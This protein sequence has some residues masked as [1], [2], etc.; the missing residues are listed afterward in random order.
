[1]VTKSYSLFHK[2]VYG[3]MVL[4]MVISA[5]GA[6]NITP[7]RAQEAG[8]ETPTETVTPPEPTGTSAPVSTPTI[9]PTETATPPEATVTPVPTTAPTEAPTEMPAQPEAAATQ[10][11]IPDFGRSGPGGA[12]QGPNGLWYMPE[13]AQEN[14]PLEAQAMMALSSSSPD[15]FGYTWDDSEAF[16]WI[17]TTGGTDTGLTG[18]G[19][20]N[21]TDLIALPFAF[22][23]YENTYS[24]VNIAAPGTLAFTQP[25]YWPSQGTIP[26]P[27]SPN[28]VIAPYWTPTYIGSGGWVHYTSGGSAPNRFFVVEWHDLTG[29]APGD[30][31][32]EDEL[33]RFEVILHENGDIVFQY[34]TMTSTGG[35]WCGTSGIEDSIGLDGLTYKNSCGGT[36][37]PSSATAVR[38]TRPAASA[39]VGLPAAN[40]GRF[41]TAGALASFQVAIRNIGELGTDTYDLTISSPWAAALYAANGTTLLT[42]TDA[43][44]TVDTGSVPQGNSATVIV[45]LQTPPGA[46]LGDAN[47][48]VLTARS[49]VNTGKSKT[50]TLKTAV[51]APFVQVYSDNADGAMSMDLVQPHAQS[52]QPAT[53]PN[54]WGY[55][56]AIARASGETYVYAWSKYGYND[57][58]SYYDLEFTLLDNTGNP[59][60]SV[61]KLTDNS[62]ETTEVADYY[63]AVAVAPDGHIG[64][65]WTHT[66]YTS[67]FSQSL[68]NVFFAILDSAGNMVMGPTNV[69]NNSAWG[70]YGD[71]NFSSYDHNQVSASGD[72]H[73]TLA[74]EEDYLGSSGWVYQIDYAVRDSA[75][76]SIKTVTQ[77]PVSGLYEFHSA[78]A[79]GGNRT[80]L[81][82][83]Y[84]YDTYYAVLDSAGSVVKGET[85]L[86]NNGQAR[87]SSDAVL[88]SNGRT[89]VAWTNYDGSY[90]G[91]DQLAFAIL[92]TSFNLY[93]GPTVLNNPAA[94]TGNNYISITSDANGH[95]ILTWMDNNSSN[96]YYALVNKSGSVNTQP[97]I[98]LTSQ[99]MGGNIITSYFGFGNASYDTATPPTVASITRADASPTSAASVRFNVTFSEPVTGVDTSDF[100]L[101]ASGITGPAV[102]GISGSLGS[103]LVTVNT[104]SG[105]GTLRLNVNDNDSIIDSSG[106][107]LG[108]TGIGNGNFTSGETYSVDKGSSTPP[109][110]P[111]LVSPADGSLS[112]DF[113]PLLDWSNSTISAG[114]IFGHYQVQVATDAAFSAIVRDSNITGISNSSY[115][116]PS[117][118]VGSTIY[119]WRVRAFNA[120][121]NSSAW[122]LVRT[123]HTDAA[124][125]RHGGWLDEIDFSVVSPGSAMAQLQAGAI[126]TYADPL[127]LTQKASIDAAGLNS[128]PVPGVYYDIMYNGATCTDSNT[129]NPFADRKIREATNRLYDR[130]YLN[131]AI[132][133]GTGVPKF[134]VIQ[135]NSSDYADLADIASGLEAKYAFN[136]SQAIADIATEMTNLGATLV[137]GKWRFHGSPVTLHFLVRSD[138]DGTRLPMGDYVTTQLVKAGFTV[139]EQ[140][141]KSSEA[142]PIWQGTSVECLWNAYTAGWMY[143]GIERD[144]KGDFQQMYLPDSIQGSQPFLSNNPDPVFQQVGDDLAN[145][146]F[147]TLLQRHDLMAQAMSLS[148]QDSLQVFIINS[149]SFAPYKTN[150][151]MSTNLASGIETA[152]IVFY[153]AHI[154]GLEGGTLKWGE[155]DLFTEP[156]NPIA[157]SNW[158][159]DQGAQAATSGGAFMS[160]PYTGLQWPLRAESAELTVQTGLPIFKSLDWITLSSAATINVPADAWVDWNATTQTFVTAGS[161]ITAKT[162]STITYPANMFD[163][164]TW[165]DG[166]KLSVADFVM[167]M[168]M[169]FDRAKPASAIYDDQAVPIFDSFMSSFKGVKIVSTSPLVIETYSDSF[170]ADAE[171]DIT[172]WWPNYGYGEASWD[173]IAVANLAEADGVSAYSYDKASAGAIDQTNFVGG[174]TLA[175]LNGYLN[176]AIAANTIP[177]APTMGTYLT[178][179]EATARYAAL[180]AFYTAHGHFW[181]GTGPYYLDTLNLVE[182][183]LALRNFEQYPDL[184]NR[185]SSFTEPRI[186]A[187][188]VT[189]P[190]R[191]AVGATPTF[192]IAVSF[193]GT[194]YP[195]TDIRSVKYLLFD[196][197]GTLVNSGTAVAVGEG[198]F[199]V[200]L[201]HATVGL[202]QKGVNRI[203]AVVV[204]NP[205]VIP[206]FSSL[207]FQVVLGVRDDYDGDGKTD[208]A[209]FYPATG[210][211]WWVKSSTGLWDGKWLGS[212]TFTYVGASDFDGDGKTDP[213]KF[214]PATGTVWWVKSS[215]G[216]LDGQWLGPD[217]FTFITGS[218]FDGDGKA[219]PAKFYPATGTVWW[220]KSTTG[221]LD[222]QWLGG[223]SFQYV[224]GSDFDGDGK[225][226]PA[227]FYPAT[228][229]VWWVK[230]TTHTI[231]GMWLGPDTFTYVP[232]SDFDGDGKTDPAKFYPAT[233]TVWWV[234]SST[235]TLDG[236]WLGPGTFTYVAG[237]DFDGDGKTDPTKYVASTHIL[238]WLKSSTGLWSSV[239][240]GT[241]TYTLALGQ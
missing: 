110:V 3:I 170:N 223:D 238:S 150:V 106:N 193:H 135:T 221:I 134:F 5:L 175:I 57:A 141:K 229:T 13:G 233:G 25:D 31:I 195:N 158:G 181:I 96:L 169:T 226:D 216:T 119:H 186:A 69:T 8:T 145:A 66:I 67:D 97:M 131:T 217:L 94:L 43:D 123:F 136:E 2:L 68:N 227:K 64:V 56:P 116:S 23:Y 208:P 152:P 215:T 65:L 6:G 235:H 42:D 204:V 53:D 236:A 37:M 58:T 168:I 17:D 203:E 188:N 196:T 52:A 160:D 38:F 18:D 45:K 70:N 201:G 86:T 155:S 126:D 128:A 197:T 234:K 14:P 143:T 179:S 124:S 76:N 49:S 239:D 122:S 191:V 121:G 75:G 112:T 209:K 10:Q 241:G 232:A 62:G 117:S 81:T 27:N 78:S 95:A 36:G 154:T 82:W 60:R 16:S 109:S 218:D 54:Y 167:Q 87:W 39:R 140:Y 212:D 213:A 72:N 114:V 240:L 166:S 7:A 4:G 89:A 214:Y 173:V 228:G 138:G 24:Q 15:D 92:D 71:L 149:R 180:K 210:T 98:F 139:D 11:P 105:N 132:Y 171:L 61:T 162:K 192:N 48:A 187:A 28:N 84:N 206:T 211:V 107:P 111:V 79:V 93:S 59:L 205:V 91:K 46:V 182:K 202:L 176:E 80:I 133:A 190:T 33:Y 146:N 159:W 83:L 178:P 101:T 104:G 21:A 200:T 22:K 219:D 156:W 100:T 153:T 225:T 55:N 73:F 174:P 118:L 51:P 120:Y 185:W 237:C 50:A 161:G 222:G 115:T 1:M 144:A 224:S 34:Q 189:G 194:P 177:Y 47:T 163:T 12:R 199:Q 63:P 137:S 183:A 125:N 184:A 44:G 165:H 41:T 172:S 90:P 198:Q 151:Q 20:N 113:T 230:S 74:W 30:T 127:S 99:A 148:L 77:L 88:L 19:W 164:V 220:V 35:Y 130:N 142:G 29:G 207:Y 129:L 157:G 26:S 85:N 103:Y 231:D 32:G 9:A 108:G 147:T 40:Q 102:T